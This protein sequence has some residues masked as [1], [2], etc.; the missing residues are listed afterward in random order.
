MRRSVCVCRALTVGT[1]AMATGGSA[2]RNDA[3]A[4]RAEH[5]QQG[6]CRRQLFVRAAPVVP[7]IPL[8]VC[9]C[10][11]VCVCVSPTDG[12]TVCCGW[13]QGDI[14]QLSAHARACGLPGR[15][16]H[17]P[18]A[19]AARRRRGRYVYICRVGACATCDVYACLCLWDNGLVDCGRV[20]ASSTDG[21]RGG[22]ACLAGTKYNVPLLNALVL[23]VGMSAIAQAQSKPPA[24][25]L[26]PSAPLDIFRQL[27]VDLDTEGASVCSDCATVCVY[28][29]VRAVC[30]GGV[31][32]SRGLSCWCL[33]HFAP[34]CVAALL[35]QVGAEGRG[36]AVP[37]SE[38]TGQPAAVPEQPHTLLQLC[39]A[40][41]VH[42]SAHPNRPRTNHPVRRFLLCRAPASCAKG[43]RKA[44]MRV[45]GDGWACACVYVRMAQGAAGASGGE[46]AAPVGSADHLYRADQ[47][48]A[49]R[50]LGQ[51]LYPRGP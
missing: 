21:A 14:G 6:P 37:V 4:A 30:T 40:V 20:G 15:P 7:R 50:L 24:A 3:V 33:G 35:T 19:H 28:V 27:T 47:D 1:P 36:R 11:C 49:L 39:A 23:H 2:A 34:V 26:A 44:L 9:V 5:V 8:S 25:P 43:R 48:A 29:C 46:S 41:P 13:A 22:R 17:A 12:G 38:C 42:R 51:A 31:R 18:V 10:V 32:T 45:W 16:A